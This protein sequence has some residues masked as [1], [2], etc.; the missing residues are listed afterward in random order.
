MSLDGYIARP[1][2][3]VSWLP[4][5]GS[6]E[7]G[8]FGYGEFMSGI[9]TVVYGRKT[10]EK[11]MTMD[12]WPF[13]EERVVVLSTGQPDIPGERRDQVSVMNLEPAPLLE[14]LAG[15]GSTGVYVDGGVT[16]QR[17]LRAGVL[18]R[19][20]VT[21]IPVLI[22]SGIPL[23]GDLPEDVALTLERSRTFSNGMIQCHYRVET[24]STLGSRT[25]E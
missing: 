3:D 13:K 14:R 20:I 12:F 8:D 6:P 10:F 18:D 7:D 17:F 23:F 1:D 16:V 4:T 24:K 5:S 21:I 15:E 2:G 11:V 9:D 25:G 22:G 19:I